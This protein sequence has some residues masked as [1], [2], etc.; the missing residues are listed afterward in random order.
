MNIIE[1]AGKNIEPFPAKPSNLKKAYSPHSASSTKLAFDLDYVRLGAL[2]LYHPAAKTSQLARELRA[3][4]RRLFRRIGFLRRLPARYGKSIAGS[5]RNMVM[6]TSSRAEE[7]KTFNALNLA[8]SLAI[9]DGVETLL[10]DADLPRPKIR[11]ALNLPDGRGLTDRLVDPSL[12][13]SDLYWRAKQAPLSVLTEGLGG[14]EKSA[15]LFAGEAAGAFWNGLKTQSPDRIVIIDA[16]PALAATEAIILARFV[17]EI[18]FVIEANATPEAA[19]AAAVDELLDVN[20]NVSL[21]LNRC[22]IGAGGSHYSSYDYYGRAPAAS[23]PQRSGRQPG[24]ASDEANN[25]NAIF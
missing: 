25:A 9:E 5:A 18:V 14:A 22:L 21:I 7:G 2:G 15:D 11:E 20:E 6:V 10:V 16:P 3:V 4:K 24:D 8:L 1:R 19:V 12:E 23:G 17:D 13:L